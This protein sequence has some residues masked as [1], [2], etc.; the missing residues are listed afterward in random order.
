VGGRVARSRQARRG[1]QSRDQ[2]QHS[3]LS[4]AYEQALLALRT[5]KMRHDLFV[6]SGM[7]D[8]LGPNVPQ[9][10][11]DQRI[12]EINAALARMPDDTGKY[13]RQYND[14]H[15]AY[16]AALLGVQGSVRSSIA[17]FADLPKD[18]ASEIERRGNA[19]ID[20]AVILDDYAN[21]AM[22][23]AGLPGGEIAWW[24]FR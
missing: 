4:L 15:D 22:M 11:I 12:A 9:A 7:L 20:A 24:V 16:L 18:F 5:P 6:A 19:L 10:K 13:V 21:R 2:P 3:T 14:A 8:L 23:L 1:H 17:S